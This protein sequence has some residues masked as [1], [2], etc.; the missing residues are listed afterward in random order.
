MNVKNKIIPIIGLQWGDEGKGKG[1][2]R[3]ASSLSKNDLI[4]RFQGGNNAGHTIYYKGKSYV[5]KLI[6]SG[7]F[8]RAQIH[9]GAGMVINPGALKDETKTIPRNVPFIKRM[10]VSPHAVLTLPTHIL[11]D[12]ISEK[13]KGKKRIGSTGRGISPSYTDLYLRRAL[14]VGDIFNKDFKSQYNALKEEHRK[15]LHNVFGYKISAN[16]LKESEKKFWG[17]IKFLRSLKIVESAQIA[18]KALSGAHTVIAEGAQGTLLDVRFGNYPFVTS[19]HTIA[20]GV[21]TGLGIPP[22]YI[23][24][25]IGIFK[26]YTTKVGEGP[27]PTELGGLKST[28]WCRDKKFAYEKEKFPNPDP[29]SKDGFEQGI[30]LRRMGFEIGAVT[31]R[32]RRTGWLDIPLLKYAIEINN[33]KEL[34]LTK[35]DVLNGFKKIKVCTAYVING[36]KTINIPFDL[37]REK[38]KCVYKTFSGWKG[39]LSDYKKKLPKEAMSYVEFLEKT[40]GAKIIYVGTGPEEH[41]CIERYW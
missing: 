16:E 39:E 29:N 3:I 27:F 13:I 5:F 14:R 8:G 18:P 25:A 35:L 24:P 34:V 40:V 7:V 32:L 31:G 30:A 12:S 10:S 1:V 41:H 15:T 9:L 38:I 11:L 19:S 20:S 6:P 17:G 37:S 4:V 21:G 33:A 36:K 2:A 22:S 23:G 28:I 26:A